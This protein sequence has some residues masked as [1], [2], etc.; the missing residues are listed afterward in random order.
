MVVSARPLWRRQS[1]YV[2]VAGPCRRRSSAPTTRSR[3]TR[4]CWSIRARQLSISSR[5]RLG[6]PVG[7][8]EQ[9]ALEIL[10]QLARGGLAERVGGPPVDAAGRHQIRRA[11]AVARQHHRAGRIEVDELGQHA[12]RSLEVLFDLGVEH[13]LPR[14][15]IEASRS[16]VDTG[17]AGRPGAP[18]DER[19]HDGRGDTTAP[20]Q[21]RPAG[22]AASAQRRAH[23]D[24]ATT[25]R[26]APPAGAARCGPTSRARSSPADRAPASRPPAAAS[27]AG[28]DRRA[29]SRRTTPGAPRTRSRSAAS[30]SP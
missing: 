14:R 13:A 2:G 23:A 30:S 28:R 21:P 27:S 16:G 3:N 1:Q 19:E 20:G 11:L 12:L 22:G 18:H 24:A 9:H 7:H 17:A 15:Q 5:R 25:P 4:S 6:R 10:E 8:V 29:G 26:R